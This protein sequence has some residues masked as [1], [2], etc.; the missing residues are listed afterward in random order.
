[1][2]HI[3]FHRPLPELLEKFKGSTFKQ[4]PERSP[5]PPS[6]FPELYKACSVVGVRAAEGME[7]QEHK[8]GFKKFNNLGWE[9]D[10]YT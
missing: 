6:R 9:T 3:L 7:G 8:R 10:R 4:K 1:M 2:D 5:D